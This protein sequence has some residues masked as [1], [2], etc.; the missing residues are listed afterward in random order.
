[1]TDIV[2]LTE[3]EASAGEQERY[4]KIMDRARSGTKAR[5]VGPPRENM[6]TFKDIEKSKIDPTPQ[7]PGIPTMTAD[8]LTART[9]AAPAGKGALRNETLQGL[10]A[11][12]QANAPKKEEEAVPMTDVVE[13]PDVEDEG[14]PVTPPDVEAAVRQ[15]LDSG[16][17][18]PV[19]HIY[20]EERRELI[21]K[22]LKPLSMS[23]VLISQDARQSVPVV[24]G[25]NIEFRTL[26]G[27]ETDF[28]EEYIWRRYKGNLTRLMYDVAKSL[29]ALTLSVTKVGETRLPESR[30]KHG[31]IDDAKF[32]AKWRALMRYP[33]FLLEA[34]DINRVWFSERCAQMLSV[35]AVGNG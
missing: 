35:D 27:H 32:E 31:E 28:I 34:M 2:N 10:Q 22:D 16:A 23:S 9:K 25:A 8:E 1:M 21:E 11:L 12:Q 7:R 15:F 18:S 19:A 4:K 33:G 17:A 29:C 24:A 3:Q 13:E 30:N 6:P 5:P 26:N 14:H 20:N